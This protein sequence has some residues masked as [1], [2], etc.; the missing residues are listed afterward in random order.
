MRSKHTS[1]TLHNIISRLHDQRSE[2][3][4]IHYTFDDEFFKK[5]IDINFSVPLD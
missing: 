1:V 2:N 3:F 4:D 5:L